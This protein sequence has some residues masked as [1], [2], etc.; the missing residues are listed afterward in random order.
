M[1]KASDDAL[2]KFMNHNVHVG[3]RII[4]IGDPDAHSDDGGHN[5]SFKT[6]SDVIKAVQL[7]E[8]IN[9]NPINVNLLSYGGDLYAGFAIYDVLTRSKCDVII[10]GFGAIMSAGSIILQAA[11]PGYRL[12]Y[13]HA[14][15]MLHAGTESFE[16]TPA[17]FQRWAEHSKR[18][19]TNMYQI[20]A[21][22]CGKPADGTHK[23]DYWRKKLANDWILSAQEAIKHN[24]ADGICLENV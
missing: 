1:A 22:K 18:T 21:D 16:G 13:P 10:R 14:A 4:H 11:T 17:D 3:A 15:V 7:L 5:V 8:S 20:Y 12:L 2:E 23:A 9:K 19:T 24:I 6:A